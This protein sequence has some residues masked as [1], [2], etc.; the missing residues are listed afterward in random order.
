MSPFLFSKGKPAAVDFEA[1]KAASNFNRKPVARL[2]ELKADQDQEALFLPPELNRQEVALAQ[3]EALTELATGGVLDSPTQAALEKAESR[4]DLQALA[5]QVKLQKSNLRCEKL[6]DLEHAIVRSLEQAVHESGLHA[7][8]AFLLHTQTR[9]SQAYTGKLAI[10]EQ[11]GM[12]LV[13]PFLQRQSQ[14]IECLRLQNPDM[15][16]AVFQAEEKILSRLKAAN[17][18][19]PLERSALLTL[20]EVISKS[21]KVLLAEKNSWAPTESHSSEIAPSDLPEVLEPDQ[22]ETRLFALRSQLK[23]ADENQKTKI[24]AEI[25]HLNSLLQN[26][27]AETRLG[28]L[29]RLQRSLDQQWAQ[30]LEIQT[31]LKQVPHESHCRQLHRDALMM[32][33]RCLSELKR[34]SQDLAL[35]YPLQAGRLG[36][37]KRLGYFQVQQEVPALSERDRAVFQLSADFQAGNAERDALQTL[38]NSLLKLSEAYLELKIQIQTALR[39]TRAQAQLEALTA[40]ESAWDKTDSLRLAQIETYWQADQ[41]QLSALQL[42]LIQTPVDR[43]VELQTLRRTIP[44]RV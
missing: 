12:A 3:T 5:R 16:G 6:K 18:L 26:L 30:L 20:A 29:C 15:L 27:E 33:N 43:L 44:A 2:R 35:A 34:G 36:F 38:L 24:Q 40:L 23:E 32:K 25:D 41:E 7:L 19:P 42:E 21:L 4:E 28:F 9:L 22:I 8:Q 11:E 39:R 1:L 31:A 14:K 10:S 17:P 37:E 13:R